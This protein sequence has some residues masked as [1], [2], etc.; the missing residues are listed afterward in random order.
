MSKYYIC[1]YYKQEIFA[2]NIV[3]GASRPSSIMSFNTLFLDP[4]SIA[5]FFFLFKTFPIKRGMF[6]LPIR[7]GEKK[8]KKKEQ[9][10]ILLCQTIVFT[11]KK[12]KKNCAKRE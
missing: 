4:L 1:T 9:D 8:K 11:K 12:K 5:Y 3:Y 10:P 2:K 6:P 7:G